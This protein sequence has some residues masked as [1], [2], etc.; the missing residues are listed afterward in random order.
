MLHKDDD[1]ALS[2][3]MGLLAAILEEPAR[4][5]TANRAAAAYPRE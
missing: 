2:Y 3:G 4:P 1:E 5:S